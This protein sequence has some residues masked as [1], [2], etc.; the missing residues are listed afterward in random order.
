[1][2]GIRDMTVAYAADRRQFGQP[3][4]R[5]QMI[6]GHSAEL[7]SETALASAALMAAIT[8]PSHRKV[9]IAKITSGRAASVVSATAHQVHGAIGIT[10]EHGLHRL[11]GSL[12]R[13]RDEYWT[14]S[15]W[16][17]QLGRTI[18]AQGP[19]SAWL[20]MTN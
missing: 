11:T 1:M 10:R 4:N 16:A 6:Q 2:E 13:W 20:E 18:A 15:S 7:A 14:E 19:E 5:F 3:L 17:A 9:A 8:E 12:W